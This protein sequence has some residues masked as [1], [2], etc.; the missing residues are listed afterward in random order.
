MLNWGAMPAC[1]IC[2]WGGGKAFSETGV[3]VCAF[4]GCTFCPL[5]SVVWNLLAT[6][7]VFDIALEPVLDCFSVELESTGNPNWVFSGVCPAFFGDSVAARERDRVEYTGG[8]F[9]SFSGLE[10][11]GLGASLFALCDCCAICSLIFWAC[12]LASSFRSISEVEAVW[13]DFSLPASE[14]TVLIGDRFGSYLLV[15]DPEVVRISDA[16][17]GLWFGFAFTGVFTECVCMRL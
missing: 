13:N 4:F 12:H 11:W 17:L 10:Y 3:W 6:V 16:F 9:E 15:S 8:A 5:L 2:F 14:P 1:C 7:F